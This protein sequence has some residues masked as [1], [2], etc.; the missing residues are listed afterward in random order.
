[1]SMESQNTNIAAEPPKILTQLNKSSASYGLADPQLLDKIDRLFACNV[2]EHVDLPQ[3]VVV[4]DQSSGKSSVLEGL[5]DLPF[6]RNSGL[7]TRFATQITFRRSP[8]KRVNASIIPAQ[9]ATPEHEQKV[10]AY[11]KRDLQHLD[12]PTFAEIIIEVQN[13]MGLSSPDSNSGNMSTFSDDILRLEI[14]GPE[15]EHLS[16]ID[17][18]GIFKRTTQGV[19]TKADMQMVKGMVHTYMKNPRSVM[20]TV[21]PANVDIATQEILEMAEEL[22]PEGHRTL[23]VLTKPDLVDK[24][25]ENAVVELI[26]GKRHPLKL[27]WTL[28]RNPGQSELAEPSAD[29]H[30]LEKSFFLRESPWNTLDKDKVGIGSLRFRLQEIL[31]GH[32]RREFPKVKLEINKR[33]K[34]CQQSLESFGPARETP[35]DQRGYLLHIAMRFQELT[36]LALQANYGGADLFDKHPRLRLVTTV[37]KRNDVLSGVVEKQG[38]TFCFDSTESETVDDADGPKAD[39]EEA[40]VDE[41]EAVDAIHDVEVRTTETHAD[42][43]DILHGQ[44][45]LP[46]S[47]R[48]GIFAWL[49][50]VYQSSRGL[51]LGTFGSSLLAITMKSQ[52]TKWNGLALGYISDIVTMVHNYIRGLLEIVCPD[53]RVRVGLVSMLTDNLVEKYKKAFNHVNFLLEVERNGIPMTQN[54][55]FS[56]NLEM[57]RQQRMRSIMEQSSFNDCKHGAVVRL[58]DLIH[59]QSMSNVDH[60]VQEMHDILAS[61]Y[62]V[63]RERFVD[64]VCKQGA[65]YH[66]ISGKHT[67]LKL[68]SPAFV[69]SMS[70]EQLEE[71]AGE[72]ASAKRTRAALNKQMK[73]LE[74]APFTGLLFA[75]YGASVLRIDR[76]ERSKP[77]GPARDLLTRH[78]TS[79]TINLKSP[80]GRS[81]LLSLLVHTDV[82][83]DPFRPGVLESLSLCPRTVLQPLNPTLIIARLTGFRRDG[84]YASMAGHDINY[85]AVSGVLSLLGRKGQPPQPPAN[86]LADFGG[87]GLMCFAG[88]L[89]ALVERA[90]TGVGQVVE[91]NMVDG[92]GYLGTMPR[93]GRKVPGL[94][95]RRRGENMLDGGCP[96]Y[97]VYETKVEGEFVAVGALEPQFYAALLKGL[98]LSPKDLPKG[99]REGPAT[100]PQLRAIFTRLFKTRTRR[101]WE[102]VFDGTDACVTPVLDHGELED[103]GYEQRPAVALKRSPGLAIAKPKDGR[104]MAANSER[105]PDEATSSISI[106]GQGNGIPGNGW[107]STG[108]PPGEGGEATLAQW[109]GWK[110]GKD[111]RIGEDGGYVKIEPAKL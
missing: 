31:A 16:V 91:A 99:R 98:E 64:A 61:Y 102:A 21:I 73:D 34:S 8:E 14:C 110:K 43:E 58:D 10:R 6:P 88:V 39:S 24:G 89:M 9:S 55:G 54:H 2:G 60:V 103:G 47:E 30:S 56:D 107:T 111:Y 46:R 27:G 104:A 79:I 45:S 70:S 95:D 26:E 105:S 59:K 71:V 78:K 63:A 100:W 74:A 4:G 51:D 12:P 36:S 84:K 62:K 22:D 77:N 97:D 109:M 3:L 75:D 13:V 66:L 18:P 44:E 81:L 29:R 106:R 42:L 65:D 108:L 85:L 83:I 32:I 15:Q 25:A 57:C 38:H 68:F 50:Q 82:L 28:V 48:D 69:N 87:G 76:P 35:A 67:P 92:A 11:T 33:I 49:E 86:L 94:W 7:C 19:T 5:T 52:S 53:E 93:L 17:V 80:G 40:V 96:Y 1:M 90:R 72:D 41:H 101:E 23:G 20:L 37:V